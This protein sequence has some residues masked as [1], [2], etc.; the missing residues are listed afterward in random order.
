MTLAEAAR[1]FA[2]TRRRTLA[3][4][5]SLSQEIAERRSPPERWSVAEVLDHLALVDRL[6]RQDV[7]R[8][9]AAGA[10]G[11]SDFVFRTMAEL[12][13]ATRGDEK[14]LLRW[15]ELP[16]DVIGALVPRTLRQALLGNRAVP[17][18]APRAIV[19]RPGRPLDRLRGELAELP[20]LVT[21]ASGR[22]APGACLYYYNPLI[23]LTGVA[24]V[25]EFLASHEGRHQAQLGEILEAVRTSAAA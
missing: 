23:G 24:G 12:D 15:V 13:P 7:E 16:F 19:P 25:L 10:A 2:A 14:L 5:E 6:L 21:A 17:A 4:V 9:L 8:L 1:H 3:L 20:E 22:I 18:R 11:R